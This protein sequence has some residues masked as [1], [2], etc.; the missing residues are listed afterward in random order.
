MMPKP[1]YM[2]N[3]ATTRVDPRVVETMLPLLSDNYGNPSNTGHLFGRRAAA[4]VESARASIAAALAAR[5]DEILFTSGATES[6][7]LAIRGVAQRYRKRGNHLIS[8]VTEHS[9][10]LETLKKLARDGFD[11][12]LLPVV[13]APSDRAGL[14]TAQSVADA[15]RDDTILVSVALANNEIGAIQPL[16]EIGRVCKERR[17]L[18]HSDATQA[19]GKMAVDV[20]RLQVDLMSFS[21]HKLYGPKGIG[22]LYVRRRHPSVWLEPLISGGGQEM[23]LRS[24]T[25]NV[26]GI[27]GFA[28]ALE[29]CLAELPAEAER[30]RS[31]RDRLFEGLKAAVSDVVLNGPALSP[32]HLRLPGNLNVSFARVDGDALLL[33]NGGFAASTGSACSS[34]CQEPS[35]VLSALGGDPDLVR[36]G[37]RFGLG[38]F[39][40]LEEVEFVIGETERSVNRLRGMVC[41]R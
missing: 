32:A 29:L 4:A 40:T 33:T 30:L 38:R 20:D 27:A 31:L 5:P 17:V 21:A 16:E 2:D 39:N 24:G 14:V 23:R 28:R 26:P 12:T 22:A 35:H 3:H 13:Q 8:V 37:V 11:V 36:G 19:V 1:V 41:E 18:L 10:V 15:I 25:L 9:S 7:N 34:S 6:N